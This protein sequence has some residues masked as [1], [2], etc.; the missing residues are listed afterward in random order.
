MA[1]KKSEKQ[2][3]CSASGSSFVILHDEKKS[4]HTVV[5]YGTLV[6]CKTNHLKVGSTASFNGNGNRSARCRGVIIFIGKFY[7]NING[8][9]TKCSINFTRSSRTM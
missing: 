7:E 6:N 3:Q 2:E 4:H 1:P 9:N 5:P 8:E